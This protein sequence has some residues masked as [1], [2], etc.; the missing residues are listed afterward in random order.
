MSANN[1]RIIEGPTGRKVQD[2]DTGDMVGSIGNGKNDI[3]TASPATQAIIEKKSEAVVAT[4]LVEPVLPTYAVESDEYLSHIDNLT[5][6]MSKQQKEDALSPHEELSYLVTRFTTIE[7]LD[8]A[9]LND[10]YRLL[11]NSGKKNVSLNEIPT[12]AEWAEWL[13]GIEAKVN[14]P[15]ID[16]TDEQRGQLQALLETVKNGEKPNASSYALVKRVKNKIISARIS[17]DEGY[18]QISAWFDNSPV[19][20]KWQVAKFRREYIEAEAQ[21]TILTVPEGYTKA[22]KMT[23]GSAP[24]DPAS[25]YAHY[26]AETPELY[27][28]SALPTKFVA[29]DTETTGFVD[30]P[31]TSIIQ[32]GLVEYDNDGHEV[33]RF[34]SYIRPPL[35][36]NGELSTGS[37]G[38]IATH[39]ILPE[40]VANAPS[41]A[42]LMP[43]L[44]EYFEGATVIGQNV[45]AFDK[46]MVER[47]Y[48]RASDGDKTAG[49]NI[50]PR[51]ADTLYFAQ[52]HLQHLGLPN[53]K[54]ETLNNHFN[55]G[56]F[57][58]HDAGADAHVAARIFFHM[59]KSLKERQNKASAERKAND[60]WMIR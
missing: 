51:A 41:F 35:D 25:I 6:H 9:Q 40:H 47:E 16:Y 33:R 45:I 17:L 60:P 44:K 36:Q 38:A 52:R 18:R 4:P 30:D 53:N 11:Y 19:D 27:D 23:S 12:D 14:D 24:K 32:V 29:F 31:G 50:W 22:Y 20:V 15:F 58:A 59:R 54:L 10:I 3:P 7:E 1:Y 46:K 28:A 8:N 37:A 26:M 42:E 43:T 57:D 48:V 39:G 56:A 2:K 55:L 13:A 5:V 21:G 34:V 49:Y